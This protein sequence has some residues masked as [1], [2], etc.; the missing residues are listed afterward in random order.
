[1]K[2]KTLFG[3]TGFLVLAS[4]LF[5]WLGVYNIAAT[6]K[7]WPI[8]VELL[9]V[10]RERSIEI[11][12]KEIVKPDTFSPQQLASGA[13]D[14]AAMCVQCHLAPGKEATA[15]HQGLYPQPPVFHERSHESHDSSET[16]W[17]IKNGIKMTGMPAWGSVHSDEE[18]W[19]MVAFI[20]QLPEMSLDK[21]QRLTGTGNE[22]SSGQ[23]ESVKPHS[24]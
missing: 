20:E 10:L 17:V 8:T 7:H 24:H 18:I 16:F 11:R 21:Y 14:Y 3:L 19:A 9:E 15:L 22:D 5:V 12:S 6:E 4:G 13:E 23:H 1:M 2:I